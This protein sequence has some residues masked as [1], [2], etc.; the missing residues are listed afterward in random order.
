MASDIDIMEDEHSTSKPEVLFDYLLLLN[1]KF[2]N[3]FPVVPEL[4][5]L[6]LFQNLAT[7]QMIKL[8]LCDV[9]TISLMHDKDYRIN[10]FEDLTL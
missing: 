2:L 7:L 6:L 9:L 1:L 5:Y 10:K 3:L 8:I 4:K